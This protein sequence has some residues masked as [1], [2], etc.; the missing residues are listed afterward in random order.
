[1]STRTTSIYKDLIVANHLPYLHDKYNV[2]PDDIDTN[3]NGLFL[4]NHIT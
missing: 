1:M 3:N 4:V 2:V